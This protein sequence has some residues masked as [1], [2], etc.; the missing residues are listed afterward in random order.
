MAPTISACCGLV[1]T[2]RAS[3][4]MPAPG[5][6]ASSTIVRTSDVG[7]LSTTYQPWSS[8]SAAAL[9]RPAPDSPVI[10]TM[11]ATGPAYRRA[12]AT[13]RTTERSVPWHR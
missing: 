13:A 3:R 9:V 5:T 8:R 7:R 6:L 1:P 10:T 12:L 2:T 4:S 11:S